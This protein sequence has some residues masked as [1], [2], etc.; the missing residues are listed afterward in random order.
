MS[1]LKKLFGR[2]PLRQIDYVEA[3]TEMANESERTYRGMIKTFNEE[4]EEGLLSAPPAGPTVE[5]NGS[6]IYKARIFGSLFIAMAYARSGHSLQENEEMMNIATGVA[7][8]S[9]QGEGDV[10]F[11]REEARPFTSTYL[12]SAFKSVLAAFEAGP[13]LPGAM[14]PQHITLSNHLHDALKESIGAERY[15]PEVR[16]RF[17]HVVRGNAAL[18]MNQA[19]RWMLR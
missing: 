9:L 2:Q 6:G 13:V 4:V 15:T 16:E 5:P 17:D 12:V 11:D 8:D 3:M 10:Y 18:A 19:R 1:F 7:L 14:T